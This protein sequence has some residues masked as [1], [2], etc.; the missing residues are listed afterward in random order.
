MYTMVHA[1]FNL[2][3]SVLVLSKYHLH[4]SLEHIGSTYMY[5]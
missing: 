4:Y 1:G 3:V 2:Q 5:K